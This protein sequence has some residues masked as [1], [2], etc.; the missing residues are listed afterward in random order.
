[1][2][3]DFE[4][5]PNPTSDHITIKYDLSPDKDYPFNI[6]DLQGRILLRGIIKKGQRETEIDLESLPTGFYAIRIESGGTTQ[7]RSLIKQ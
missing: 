5:F 2:E 3:R 7:V 1:M 4:L 6:F